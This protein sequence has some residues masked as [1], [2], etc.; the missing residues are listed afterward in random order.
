MLSKRTWNFCNC[1]L[2]K[3]QVIQPEISE[4]IGKICMTLSFKVEHLRYN[5]YF[6]FF[7]FPGHKYFRFIQR[8]CLQPEIRKVIHTY[9]W[10]LFSRSTIK[11]RWMIL[12]LF[13]EI[14]DIVNVRIDTNIRSAAC[15][16]Y[17]RSWKRSYNECVWPWVPRSTV[18]FMLFFSTFL[19]SSTLKM[20]DN[21]IEFVSCIT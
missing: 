11:V 14:L 10:P 6:T 13:S 17:S 20:L 1:W 7:D 9:V 18:T 2:W 19:I 16:V 12:S 3:D 21:T 5:Y 8:S 4:V 15:I